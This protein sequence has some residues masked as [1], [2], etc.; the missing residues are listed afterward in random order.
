M[1]ERFQSEIYGLATEEGATWF[2]A[3]DSLGDSFR[4]AELQTKSDNRESIIFL[5]SGSEAE[6]SVRHH[7]LKSEK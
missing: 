5:V 4:P 6:P 3:V 1:H 2:D 7:T